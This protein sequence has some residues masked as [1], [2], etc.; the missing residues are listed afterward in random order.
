MLR[1][2]LRA[3]APQDRTRQ[4]QQPEH[5]QKDNGATALSCSTPTP[6]DTNNPAERVRVSDH[7]AGTEGRAVLIEREMQH[8]GYK[9]LQALIA[10]Y[11]DQ[12]RAHDEIPMLRT[13]L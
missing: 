9:A 13:V 11:L 7:P 3:F 5:H 2:A 6:N 10:D 1:S 4:P 12:A 8:D